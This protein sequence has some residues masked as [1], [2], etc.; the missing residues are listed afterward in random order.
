MACRRYVRAGASS[1]GGKRENGSKK[2]LVV[3]GTGRVG[4]SSAA[5]LLRSEHQVTLTGRSE[6]SYTAALERLPELRSTAFAAVDLA[7]ADSLKQQAAQHDLV[8]PHW[9]STACVHIAHPRRYEQELQ[10]RSMFAHRTPMRGSSSCLRRG[11][12]Q[13]SAIRLHHCGNSCIE[14]NLLRSVIHS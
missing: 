2:I 12:L 8:L 4:S 14:L 10:G 11:Q 1:D 9:F 3:G 7:G 6:A 5:C 13:T